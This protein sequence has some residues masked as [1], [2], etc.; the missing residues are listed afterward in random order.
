MFYRKLESFFS[1]IIFDHT[2]EIFLFFFF[3]VIIISFKINPLVSWKVN[4]KSSIIL[5]FFFLRL[6]RVFR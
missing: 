2:R 3:L 5:T 4:F 6:V 1:R